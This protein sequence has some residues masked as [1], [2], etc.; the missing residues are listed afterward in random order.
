M[1]KINGY[2]LYYKNNEPMYSAE[3]TFN[4]K[5]KTT[6]NEKGYFELFVPKKVLKLKLK[7]TFIGCFTINF[8]NLPIDEDQ[9]DLDTIPM[10]EY[11]PGYDMTHFDCPPDD[12][13]CQKK[14]KQHQIQENQ[15]IQD[16][17]STV[18]KSITTY[19]YTFK[20]N[21]YPINCKTGNIDLR[22]R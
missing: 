11:F 7:V 10:F 9:I 17:Y 15:R 13:E 21:T 4:S 1:A 8:I 16:Y 18:N 6:A 14:E 19:I 2:V 20:G 22:K 12:L 5:Y 3:I